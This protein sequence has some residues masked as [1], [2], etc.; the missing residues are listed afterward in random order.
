MRKFEESLGPMTARQTIA[1]LI[2]IVIVRLALATAPGALALSAFAPAV[3]GALIVG[4]NPRHM[5]HLA[6]GCRDILTV[7]MQ[8]GTFLRDEA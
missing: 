4:K 7:E 6:A 1:A 2:A 5:A 3:G 8:M